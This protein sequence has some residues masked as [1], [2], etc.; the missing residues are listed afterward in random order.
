M[1]A[2]APVRAEK[3]GRLP[4]RQV[5]AT[6]ATL[7][8]LTALGPVP[9]AQASTAPALMTSVPAASL[10]AKCSN[11]KIWLIGIN[12]VPQG[13]GAFFVLFIKA[14]PGWVASLQI[15][16]LE[17]IGTADVVIKGA[18]FYA[19]DVNSS[20]KETFG[21]DVTYKGKLAPDCTIGEGYFN[22]GSPLFRRM[23]PLGTWSGGTFTATPQ[24]VQPATVAL[25]SPAVSPSIGGTSVTIT[26]WGFGVPGTSVRVDF[27]PVGVAAESMTAIDFKCAQSTTFS[28]K[29]EFLVTATV[30]PAPAGVLSK[31][32]PA[33]LCRAELSVGVGLFTAANGVVSTHLASNVLTFTYRKAS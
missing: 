32:S 23:T 12:P 20:D 11:V 31:C 26:G 6:L 10:Q 4:R 33:G 18:S 29:S 27:C 15:K 17:P 22:I 7:L 1:Q 8:A 2:V 19:H 13:S 24:D 16:P 25:V 5:V 14:G 30:P 9:L 28:V 21:S 3:T